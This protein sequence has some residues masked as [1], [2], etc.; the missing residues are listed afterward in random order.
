MSKPAYY[1]PVMPYMIV[2]DAQA[3][4]RFVQQTFTVEERALFYRDD[5]QQVIMHGEFSIGKATFMFAEAT[6]EWKSATCSMFLLVSD[7]DDIHQKALD[8]GAK[9]LQ[10]PSD[11]DYGRSSG[12]QDPQGNTWWITRE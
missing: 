8:A 11:M 3:L 4:Y 7:V 10:A 1:L 2:A 5:D 12:F 6:E 9:E